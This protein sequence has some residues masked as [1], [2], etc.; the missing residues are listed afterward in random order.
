MATRVQPDR[1]ASHGRGGAGNIL[2]EDPSTYTKPEDLVTP[3]IKS[4]LYTTGRGGNGNMA[5][6]D[7]TNPEMARLA[8]DVI[9]PSHTETQPQL[10]GRGGAG[11]Y[12]GQDGRRKS[13]E[14]KGEEG[15]ASKGLLGKGM[16]FLQKLKN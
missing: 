7:L 1:I 13:G 6:N 14:T 15:G 2:K 10:G 16:E 5:H 3:T 8:Q 11:N 12:I 9:A 4:N